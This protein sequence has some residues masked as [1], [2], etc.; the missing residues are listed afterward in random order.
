M[1]RWHAG[2]GG[3]VGGWGS[4]GGGRERGQALRGQL[5]I[6]R[7]SPSCG[8]GQM[9]PN[10]EGPR[11]SCAQL[12]AITA[13]GRGAFLLRSVGEKL[14]ADPS[15]KKKLTLHYWRHPYFFL[16]C[17]IA[18]TPDSPKGHWGLACR[19]PGDVTHLPFK[20][21]SLKPNTTKSF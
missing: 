7:L 21:V 12:L 20:V 17:T 16:H 19:L 2:S 10:W 6:R 3:G 18:Q 13:R 14:Y 11:V 4:G 1:R 9:P 5:K 8:Q 15:V